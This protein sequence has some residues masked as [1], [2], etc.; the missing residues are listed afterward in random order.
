MKPYSEDLRKA[1][2]NA[3]LDGQGSYSKVAK[4]FGVHEKSLQGWVKMERNG[5][6]Q[7]PRGKGHRPRAFSVADRTHIVDEINKN[8]SITLEALRKKI[9]IKVN[10]SVYWRALR[11]LGFTYK[12]KN[13][14]ERART[15][16]CCSREERMGDV[17][18]EM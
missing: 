8:P 16:R 6:A 11:E 3:Y 15:S 4:I 17:A 10:L 13:R 14:S 1:A 12:K 9:G 5:E 7:V 18:K 2:V